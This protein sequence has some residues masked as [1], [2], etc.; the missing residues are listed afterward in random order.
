MNCAH[1][2]KPHNQP[3]GH[4]NRAAKRGAP[5]YCGKVCFGLARRKH[6]TVAQKVEEKRIYDEQ[7][8]IKNAARLKAEKAAWHKKTYD[9]EKTRLYNQQR[10]AQHIEYCRRAEYKEYKKQYDLEY[11]NKQ[12]FGEFWEAAILVLKVGAEIASRA[13]RYEIYTQN[14]TINKTQKRKRAYGNSVR[15]RT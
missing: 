11:R 3:T 13:T 4:V 5:V 1:C 10:M 15:N 6:K 2:G 8:R 9:A 7:Y 12:D 14:D